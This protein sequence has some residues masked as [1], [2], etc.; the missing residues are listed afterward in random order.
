MNVVVSEVNKTLD[1]FVCAYNICVRIA[2]L[3]GTFFLRLSVQPWVNYLT[4]L[5]E[6]FLY[7]NVNNS[8]LVIIRNIV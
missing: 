1:V 7:E 3:L 6:I 4:S 5:Y 8:A 2:F